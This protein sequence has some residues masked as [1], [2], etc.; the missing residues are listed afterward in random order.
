MNAE[1]LCQL[2]V[3]RVGAVELRKEFRACCFRTKFT[4][5]ISV[6]LGQ[7]AHT[8][9][10]FL[11][12]SFD[13]SGLHTGKNTVDGCGDHDLI[14]VPRG[15]QDEVTVTDIDVGGVLCCDF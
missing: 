5:P 2:A 8:T 9:A 15:C 12:R 6:E 7:G 3:C 1:L 11:L 10:F 4:D 13:R 14:A